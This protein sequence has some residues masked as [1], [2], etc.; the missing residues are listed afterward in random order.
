MQ[1]RHAVD[2]LYGDLVRIITTD[3]TAGVMLADSTAGVM[4]GSTAGVMA[5]SP[6]GVMDDG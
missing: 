4:A 3:S 1:T 2:N 6:A 5:G